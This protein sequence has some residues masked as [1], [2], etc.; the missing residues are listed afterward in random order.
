[1]S[2]RR[3]QTPEAFAELYQPC[4]Y[5]V[6]WGGR[7]G[8]KSTAFADALLTL[9]DSKPLRI[10]C[11]REIQ[12]SIRESVH[13]L[14]ADRAKEHGF[15]VE[16]KLAEILHP[17]GSRF[18]FE[19]LWNNIDSIK[20]M[21]G[22][23]IVWIEEANTVSEDSWRK[24]IPTIRKPGSE[25]WASFNPELKSDPAYKRF[26]IS[27]PPNAIIRKVSWR[28]NPW[29]TDEMRA[30][31]EHLKAT[32]EAEYLHVWE[33]ELRQ[34]ADGS[35]YARQL[36]SAREDGRICRIPVESGIP[37]NTFWD[38][39]K[40]DSTAIWF[41]QRV[42]PQN[43]F[44]D[45]EECRLVDLDY[46]V[47]ALKDRGYIYGTHY[48]PHDVDHDLLGM[49]MTRRQQLE[50]QGVKPISVVERINS[51]NEGIEM[52]RRQFSTCWFDEDRCERGLEALAGY[53]Y[54]FDEKYRTFRPTPLHNW[55]SNGADAFRQF[56]QGYAPD[57]GWSA[58][59]PDRPMSERRA[60]RTKSGAFRPAS[61]WMT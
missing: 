29:F 11:A 59:M 41:H 58:R 51:I 2:V 48:L 17:N 27:P 24:L 61:N 47:K 25:I 30:E 7:G 35:I 39:G 10:L 36:R 1:M 37:V 43:R 33:G 34:F 28:D 22:V 53:Q 50:S 12:R 32:D 40:N 44:I 5:K 55:A 26:V 52:T 60:A 3:I 57:R 9:A 18:F 15:P 49:T 19:G 4:R 23:D 42:G 45:Y 14:L 56:G 21:E 6:Y 20:S 8:A 13:Q 46:Y 16:V 31:M 54:V 38:L